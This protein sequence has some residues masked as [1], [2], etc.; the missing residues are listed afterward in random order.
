MSSGKVGLDM[1]TIRL[2]Y[3]AMSK[4]V[5]ETPGYLKFTEAADRLSMHRVTLYDWLKRLHISPAKLGRNSMLSEEDISRIE[6]A[7]QNSS[8]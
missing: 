8:E 4:R 7:R 1:A 2:Y 3:S 6:K 5:V